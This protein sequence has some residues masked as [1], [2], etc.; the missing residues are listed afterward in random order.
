MSF[1]EKQPIAF[2]AATQGIKELFKAT[3][4]NDLINLSFFGSFHNGFA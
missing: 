4:Y 2:K 3:I 1:T